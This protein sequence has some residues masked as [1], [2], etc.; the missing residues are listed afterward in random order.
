MGNRLLGLF[1]RMQLNGFFKDSLLKK[2]I[3]I[4]NAIDVDRMQ[5]DELKREK[6]Y[7]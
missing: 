1:R 6:K 7:V 5:F 4:H 2:S 3:V